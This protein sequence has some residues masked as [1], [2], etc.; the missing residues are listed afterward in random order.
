MITIK[1]AKTKKELK[2]FIKF[3]FELYK[4][5]PYWIP[6]IINDELEGL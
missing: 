1:E 3:S 6:P 2:E 4:D 5:N